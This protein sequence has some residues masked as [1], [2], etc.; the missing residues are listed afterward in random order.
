MSLL[1]HL[2]VL[3]IMT[4]IL[5]LSVMIVSIRSRLIFSKKSD[6][7]SPLDSVRFALRFALFST[8]FDN[9]LSSDIINMLLYITNPCPLVVKNY[10]RFQG[11][12]M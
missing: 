2:E 4:E 3:E 12:E 7:R 8:L 6:G 5:S 11:L 1:A 9:T 10:T